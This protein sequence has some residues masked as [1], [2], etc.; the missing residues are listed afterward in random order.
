MCVCARL[1]WR[2]ASATLPPTAAVV[3]RRRQL[4][5]HF[6]G[7]DAADLSV[8]ISVEHPISLPLG[9][10]HSRR[11]GGRSDTTEV[12]EEGER[13]GRVKACQSHD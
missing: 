5:I 9:C 3:G 1:S 13:H 7:F 2:V 11:G 10:K 6:E 8:L 4:S 12:E